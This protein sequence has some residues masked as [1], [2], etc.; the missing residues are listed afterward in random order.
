MVPAIG[1]L[2]RYSQVA[3][4][5]IRS[6]TTQGRLIDACEYLVHSNRATL[7]LYTT[8]EILAAESLPTDILLVSRPS[9]PEELTAMARARELG[10]KVILDIDDDLTAIPGWSRLDIEQDFLHLLINSAD[11]IS[12]SNELLASR[13]TSAQRTVSIIRTGFYA[14]KYDIKTPLQTEGSFLF[15]MCNADNLK[16]DDFADDFS[17]LIFDFVSSHPNIFFDYYGDDAFPAPSHDR[18]QSFTEMS[19]EE[20][21]RALVSKPYALTVMMLGN[22]DTER[23]AL[24]FRSKSAV[25]YWEHGGLGIPGLF[26]DAEIY[27]ACIVNDHNGMI[28]ANNRDCWL[29]KLNFAYHNR[30]KLWGMGQAAKSDVLKNHHISTTAEDIY[31]MAIAALR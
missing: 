11:G 19:F 30:Q 6:R 18:I 21:K 22:R 17:Q 7:R 31:Q 24:F 5:S 12:V 14:E 9:R 29:K 27:R 3:H 23:D 10:I 25:K 2:D 15:T 16:S 4:R 28:T 1:I 8:T 20:H 13:F 26:S